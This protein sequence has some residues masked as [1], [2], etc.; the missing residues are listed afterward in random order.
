MADS[1]R[2]APGVLAEQ[3][4]AHLAAIIESSDDAIISKT[5]EGIILTWNN[6]AT[7]LYGYT[8]EEAIG[9]P[10]TL[11]L[12][13]DRAGEETE[14]LARMSRG[15]RVEYFETVRRTKN[16]EL[17][18][19]SLT[20][21][22]IRDRHGRITG[23]SHVARNISEHRRM[24][25]RLEQL[26]AIVESAEDAI[27]SKTLEGR[28]LTWN[29]GAE[30]VYGYQASEAIGRTMTTLL[31]EA[32]QNEENEILER[33]ARGERVEHFET[34]RLTRSGDLI[35]VSLTIS[36][37]RDRH[38]GIIGASHVARNVTERHQFEQQLRHTQKL[39]SLG[40]LAGGVA[41]D[42]NNLLTGIL[43]NA[44]L[45]LESVSS[46]HPARGL[47]RDVVQASERA[48]HLTRQLL[49]YAGK[50]RFIIEPVD[51]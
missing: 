42:F 25:T 38:G 9:K 32:R 37:I 7:R 27:I 16:G 44:S 49:A 34:T 35:D 23:A 12:P 11:L 6:G 14:I 17:I 19:V 1:I 36:P 10:M 46:H 50:G 4:A 29:A 26:A 33:I 20:I 13:D 41:H 5:L 2:A 48:S 45:A 30:R 8:A 31:P 51:I 39:E 21:S 43:G 24:E 15:E 47:L 28:I 3:A 40:V 22:P 18:D